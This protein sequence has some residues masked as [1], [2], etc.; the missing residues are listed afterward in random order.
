MSYRRVVRLSVCRMAYCMSRNGTPD[1]SPAVQK[2]RRSVCGLIVCSIPLRRL[3]VRS[4]PVAL[5]LDE[6]L[7][8]VG[9][10]DFGMVHLT[11]SGESEAPPWPRYEHTGGYVATE[12]A[13]T[14]HGESHGE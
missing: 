7:V 8:A 12:W 6:V 1:I 3:S 11:W 13:Q 2:V 10:G 14:L 9:E 4:R 5:A